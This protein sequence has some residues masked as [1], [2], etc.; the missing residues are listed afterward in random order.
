MSSYV[1]GSVSPG[2]GCVAGTQGLKSG[3]ASLV[4]VSGWVADCAGGVV[5]RSS[6]GGVWSD[7]FD[8][9]HRLVGVSGPGGVSMVE[10][11]GP[12]GRWLQSGGGRR[13]LYLPGQDVSVSVASGVVSVNRQFVVPGGGVVGARRSGGGVSFV[14][15]DVQGSVSWMVDAVSGVVSRARYFPFGQVRG[16]VNQM[17][18]DHGF[19]GQ[20][21]DDSTGLDYL[22]NRYYD[23]VTGEFLSVDPKVSKTGDPYLYAGGNPTTLS[24]PSGLDPDTDVGVRAKA[25]SNGYCSYSMAHSA[26]AVCGPTNSR[27][28]GKMGS[29]SGRGTF[30]AY[31]ISSL[32]DRVMMALRRAFDPRTESGPPNASLGPDARPYEYQ[33]DGPGYA[34]SEGLSSLADLFGA[35]GLARILDYISAPSAVNQ[36]WPEE[37]DKLAGGKGLDW[38]GPYQVDACGSSAAGATIFCVAS[39]RLPSGDAGADAVTYG[40]FIFYDIND[41]AAAVNVDGTYSIKPG[42]LAHEMVHVAQW[43]QNGDAF[44]E[45]Y[46]QNA[47]AWEAEA[48]LVGP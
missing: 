15:G 23:P 8:V 27:Y 7:V 37:I 30:D 45:L 29:P 16:V 40:H 3:L 10:V 43:E 38:S 32:R 13:V 35:S 22:N 42:F 34:D 19:V 44:V 39:Q 5:S 11:Y 36:S 26:G 18:T 21:E 14:G 12:G 24:D 17:P 1:Y 20:V 47:G 25:A 4:G 6:A 2:S 28:Y 46:L 33:V 41:T 48:Y 31:S 9:K